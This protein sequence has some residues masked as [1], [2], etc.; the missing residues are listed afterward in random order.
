MNRLVVLSLPSHV[1]LEMDVDHVW[2]AF[3]IYS[4]LLDHAERDA[5]LKLDHNAPSQ[6]KRIHPTLQAHNH[7]MRGTG[8][9]EWNHS[10]ELHAWV[11]V[12]EDGVKHMSMFDNARYIQNFF[13]RCLRS[14]VIDGINMGCP[15]CGY[16]DCDNPLESVRDQFCTE[17]HHYNNECLVTSCPAPVEKGFKTCVDSP[18]QT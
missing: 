10:C 9:E 12:D 4:L 11:Y 15:C 16:H 14:V 17:H 2:D 8:Q 18:L 1:S 5:V 7:R 6:A 13:S 3:F